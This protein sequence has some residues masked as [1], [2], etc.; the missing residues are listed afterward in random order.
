MRHKRTWYQEGQRRA[1]YWI[2]LKV[3]VALN[4]RTSHV[5]IVTDVSVLTVIYLDTVQKDVC[6]CVDALEAYKGI[7]ALT[8]KREA[9]LVNIATALKF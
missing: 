1:L 6:I 2:I 9:F 4:Q 8:A 3:V 7:F 5:Y